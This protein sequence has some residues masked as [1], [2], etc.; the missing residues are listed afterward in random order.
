MKEVL[1]LMRCWQWV[2]N[3]FV[4]FPL[5]FGH[6]LLNG[7]L[8][9]RCIETAAL[10]C[11]LSS[12][13]YCFNDICDCKTDRQHPVKRLRPL[14]SGRMT[15]QQAIV[16]M[17]LCLLAAIGGCWLIGLHQLLWVFALYVTMNVAYSVW[18]KHVPIVDVVVLASFYVV[19]LAAG[20]VATD[21]EN[22]RWIVLMTFLLAL[23]LGLGKRRDDV[24]KSE[25]TGVSMRT[26]AS[27][28]SLPFIHTTM[29]V[30]GAVTVVCYIMYTLSDDVIERVGNHYLYATSV[31]V[32]VAV[33]R[34]LQLAIGN[35][36]GGSPTRLMLRDHFLQA[37]VAGWFLCYVILLYLTP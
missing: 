30:V 3:V 28:Y 12:A 20:A 33:M 22:S 36:K 4:F 29:G 21:I 37:C 9:V 7:Q 18:L 35:G 27:G 14:A 31:F 11:L 16:V 34:Y 32:L 23:L 25:E 26:S 15:V 2:K 19:R 13:V 10:F 6:Q 5:F 1:Q 24:V 8:L 17:S